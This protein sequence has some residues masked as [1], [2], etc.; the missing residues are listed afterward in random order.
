MEQQEYNELLN[1]YIKQIDDFEISL[2]EEEQKDL[3]ELER[4]SK[5]CEQ[6]DLLSDVWD[7]IKHAAMDSV[8]QIIELDSRM[9]GRPDK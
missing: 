3:E 4:L 2:S 8:S 6:K 9:D 5:E 1:D 7:T